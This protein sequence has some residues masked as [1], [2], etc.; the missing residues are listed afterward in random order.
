MWR[1]KAPVQWAVQVKDTIDWLDAQR[2]QRYV[3]NNPRLYAFQA[4]F[5]ITPMDADHRHFVHTDR[6]LCQHLLVARQKNTV[7]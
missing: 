7:P 4:K 1:Q 3:L 2:T 6:T 5:V